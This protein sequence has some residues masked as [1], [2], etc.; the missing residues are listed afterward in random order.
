MDKQQLII[1]EL[2]NKLATA[3]Y[4]TVQLRAELTIAN[5]R[6]S[7]LEDKLAT[8]MPKDDDLKGGDE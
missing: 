5:Q 1:N 8:L 2:L 6:N 7:E 3:Q 4:E